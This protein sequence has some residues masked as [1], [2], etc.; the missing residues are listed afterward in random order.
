MKTLNP[1]GTILIIHRSA[2]LNTLPVFRHAY[3]R[4]NDEDHCYLDIVEDMK[5]LNFDVTW[6]VDIVPVLMPRVSH[7]PLKN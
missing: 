1:G 7:F 2:P 6:N 4:I 5:S 3:Q